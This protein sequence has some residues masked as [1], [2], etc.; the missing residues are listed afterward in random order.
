VMLCASMGLVAVQKT[1]SSINLQNQRMRNCQLIDSVVDSAFRNAIPFS[2]SDDNTKKS[3]IVFAGEP[4]RITLAYQHRINNL[5]EGG[6]RF[7]S[8]YIEN[9]KLI[10]EYRK[11]PIL[12]WDPKT[13]G[14]DSF[15][16]VLA[17][18]VRSI[19][20]T[21]ADTQKQNV[22][23]MNSWDVNYMNI[24]VAI[25]IKVEWMNGDSEVWLRRT[26]GAGLRETYGA[27]VENI[28]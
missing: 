4:G 7:I 15:R 24:P 14:M 22:V 21:Y 3:R 27:R 9:E 13:S 19:S 5:S 2:W 26:A 12:P 25:Q 28:N 6:I 11:T 10:A 8:L 20:F 18:N 16:D 17:E 1:W 23:W